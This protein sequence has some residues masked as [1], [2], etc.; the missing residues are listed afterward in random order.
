MTSAEPPNPGEVQ[1]CAG[2]GW[3][4]LDRMGEAQAPQVRCVGVRVSKQLAP[5][6]GGQ[7][8][9]PGMHSANTA[10][11][12]RARAVDGAPEAVAR[13]DP[14]S[15]QTWAL[16]CAGQLSMIMP[17][18]TAAGLPLATAV[19]AGR[20][21]QLE[22][23]WAPCHVQCRGVSA[24]FEKVADGAV[25]GNPS[26]DGNGPSHEEAPAPAGLGLPL[27]SEADQT[28]RAV[29]RGVEAVAGRASS[30]VHWGATS[31]T[32]PS[33][34]ATNTANAAQRICFQAGKIAKRSVEHVGLV[35]ALPWRIVGGGA[36]AGDVSENSDTRPR[37]R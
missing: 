21:S 2:I 36:G 29:C 3:V 24:C 35:V 30:I 7:R 19:M 23:P 17:P 13:D 22:P 37:G 6:A 1:T 9:E 11:S 32:G 20:T 28:V 27:L 26:R 18:T 10:A 14:R 25:A 33:R 12:R 16:L 4:K 8:T 5:A 34:L 31:G 15:D